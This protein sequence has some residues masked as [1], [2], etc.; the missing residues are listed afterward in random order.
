MV[1]KS[2]GSAKSRPRY[3]ISRFCFLLSTFG[4]SRNVIRFFL[5]RCL[6]LLDF[7]L[8]PENRLRCI[9]PRMYFFSSTYRSAF[10]S[11]FPSL[12]VPFHITVSRNSRS[13]HPLLFSFFFLSFLLFFFSPP[14]L[15]FSFL[16]S[17]DKFKC[18]LTTREKLVINNTE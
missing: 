7:F 16:Y 17:R 18:A 4:V 10:L 13:G 12:S 2:S 14:F 3:C 9:F 11:I 1:K 5:F 8:V 6:F 15:F